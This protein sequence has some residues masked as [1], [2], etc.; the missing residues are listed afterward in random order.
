MSTKGFLA[1]TQV[2]V[3]IWLIYNYIVLLLDF[4]FFFDTNNFVNHSIIA[5]LDIGIFKILTTAQ[6]EILNF[7]FLILIL[8]IST[9]SV[10]K[11]NHFFLRI[12]TYVIV[13]N[14]D[15]YCYPILDGGNNL[16]HIFLF[17]L[18]FVNID[19]KLERFQPNI[20]IPDINKS[21]LLLLRIQLCLVYLVAGVNKIR[22]ELWSEGTALF[23]TLSVPDYSLPFI[24]NNISEIPISLI[25]ITNYLVILYQISFSFLVWS[26]LFKNY[27]LLFGLLFHTAIALIMGLP[28]FA[29]A[30]LACYFVFID[31]SKLELRHIITNPTRNVG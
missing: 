3:S 9:L 7:S 11:Y 28:S 4:S 10:F 13:L 5:Y 29:G 8:T 26:K 30:L 16:I 20:P 18:I 21:L 19:S 17:F 25:V 31:L 6:S 1:N 24:Y 15:N 14:L 22:V 2:A 27:I 23:Y 12:L